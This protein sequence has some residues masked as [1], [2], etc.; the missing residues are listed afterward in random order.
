M[1]GTIAFCKVVAVHDGDCALCTFLFRVR[2][3][4]LAVVDANYP[5]REAISQQA[6]HFLGRR[7]SV[8]KSDY[9][10]L[11]LNRD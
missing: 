1:L 8:R 4:R 11:P 9:P 7:L 5:C 3:S 10:R 6:V 2:P